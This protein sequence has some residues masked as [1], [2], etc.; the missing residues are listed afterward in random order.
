M[1]FGATYQHS[2]KVKLIAPLVAMGALCVAAIT[3]WNCFHFW[4]ILRQ[5]LH[6]RADNLA[7]AVGFC[8]QIVHHTNELQ[9]MIYALGGEEDVKLI[10]V[11]TE[12]DDTIVASTKGYLLDKPITKLDRHLVNALRQS[13][14]HSHTSVIEEWQASN[15]V[16]VLGLQ[17][18]LKPDGKYL[19]QQCKTAILIQI[20]TKPLF[21]YFLKQMTK[22]TLLASFCVVA[23][24]L[25]GYHLIEMYIVHPIRRIR[26]ALAS[27]Y[28]KH[29]SRYVPMLA[30]DEIG[31]LAHTL[32]QAILARDQSEAL[33]RKLADLAPALTWMANRDGAP[34][35]FNRRWLQ[36]FGKTEDEEQH[37]SWLDRIHPDC[38]SDFIERYRI[39]QTRHEPFTLECRL[40]RCDGAYRWMLCHA[41]PRFLPD[42]TYEGYIG[43]LLD[44]T[45]QKESE[46]KLKE[47][48]EQLTIARD[49]AL[50]SA[51]AKAAFL[52]TMSH[53][54]R[55][56]MNGILGFAALLQNT[57]LNEQQAFFTKNIR[58]ST[59]ILSELLNQILEFSKLEAGKVVLESAPFSI[60]KLC[61][62]I[63]DLFSP[64]VDEKKLSLQLE[65]DPTLPEQVV[66]DAMRVR[67]I[68]VNLIS[69]AV[70]FTHKGGVNVQVKVLELKDTLTVKVSVRDTGVG[71]SAQFKDKIF[72]RFTQEDAS[73]TRKYG[74]TGLGLAIAQSLVKLMGGEIGFSSQEGAG[75]TFYFTLTLPVDLTQ[76]LTF[77]ERSTLPIDRLKGRRLVVAEDNREN[78]IVITSIL[79]HY[80][81]EV[82]VVPN[83]RALLKYLRKNRSVDAILMDIQMPEMDGYEAT[84][85]IREGDA[86]AKHKDQKIIGITAFASKEDQDKALQS[87]M[88]AYLTKP[89][90]QMQLLT[91]LSK[92][93]PN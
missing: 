55:T 70:K 38:A 2:I 62:E 65:I 3:G 49:A 39:A 51:D 56:P 14:K 67:Q 73:T 31:V 9:R 17:L 40:K 34:V 11:A 66:G 48:A 84:K 1:S 44:L 36:F 52:A 35:N 37:I 24:M 21:T 64:M 75:A 25:V 83:G 90:E 80:G 68:L 47:Y 26:N 43:C 93:S 22:S 46:R 23:L 76:Q 72:E 10:L 58:S 86:G 13:L 87:G 8:T 12:F 88:D 77:E 28:D 61:R 63:C 60:R 89:I 7:H 32:N 59:Q 4:T 81:A 78:Q 6:T 41:V 57:S 45:T 91:T 79:E 50:R 18:M 92:I 53:E 15:L 16:Y 85:R 20:D 74:G 19:E 71:I 27:N 82:T 29:Q 30:N 54:I 33:F 69:N 5:Q 42:G